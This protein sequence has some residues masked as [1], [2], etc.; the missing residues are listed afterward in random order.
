MEGQEDGRFSGSG[1]DD[2][3]ASDGGERENKENDRGIF[4]QG[5]KD[6]GKQPRNAPPGYPGNGEGHQEC[7]GL[8]KQGRL[9]EAA[10]KAGQFLQMGYQAEIDK[11]SKCCQGAEHRI[12]DKIAH[13]DYPATVCR[14]CTGAEKRCSVNSCKEV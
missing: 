1:Y 10:S 3:Y 8:T 4:A 6:K 5:I 7:V 12:D 14:L 13:T 11:N 9:G 2:G